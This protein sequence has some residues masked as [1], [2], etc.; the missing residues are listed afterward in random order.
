MLPDYNTC[1][2]HIKAYIKYQY[3]VPVGKVGFRDFWKYKT[4]LENRGCS[5]LDEDNLAQT[6]SN[7]RDFLIS[8]GMGG[9]GG[10][11][12]AT[13]R[14]MEEILGEVPHYDE[15]RNVKLGSG[16]ISDYRDQLQALYKK[17][18]GVTNRNKHLDGSKS[19]I[20]GK[21]KT[22][23][24]IWGQTPGFDSLNRTRFRR[25]T[26]LPEPRKLFYLR[27]KDVWYEPSEFYSILAELDDWVLRWPESNNGRIFA[28]SFC[29][30]CPGL[31]VGR[32]IDMI[33]NWKLADPRVD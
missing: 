18:D 28:D 21:S 8:Y 22:L 15:I 7:L 24:A 4:D 6:A 32:I 9:F 2:K 29:D 14:Q 17:L 33:Y 1:R 5:I 20:T 16:R 12:V 3:A 23:L 13:I 27:R 26:H 19:S 11:C 31:P 25:W 10:R 30:L